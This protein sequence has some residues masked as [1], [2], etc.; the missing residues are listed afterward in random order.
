MA[1]NP[2][3]PTHED[4]V[5]AFRAWLGQI[6]RRYFVTGLATLFPIWATLFLVV[7]LF[8]MVDGRLRELLGLNLP[9]LGLLVTVLIILA[10]GV[11]TVHFFGRVLVATIETW[12]GRVPLIKSIYPAIKQLARFLFNEEGKLT[13]FQRVVLV[14][15]PRP[16]CHSLAFVTNESSTAVT[17]SSKMLLTL[18][19]PTPP[20]PFTGPIVFLPEDEVTPLTMT[21]EEALKLVVSG[22]V[23]GAPLT[24]AK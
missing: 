1:D 12:L 22:G 5:P 15:Y 9:G 20:S 18:L 11:L 14:E 17:G 7:E 21:V 6:L 2:S 24:A 16:G 4:D 13:G 3:P 8:K 19:I 10:V 23:V